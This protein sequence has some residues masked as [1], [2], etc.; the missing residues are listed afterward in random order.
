MSDSVSTSAQ[1]STEIILG[2]NEPENPP[3]PSP[4]KSGTGATGVG[5][6]AGPSSSGPGGGSSEPEFEDV[7]EEL[8]EDI[9]QIIEEPD[10]VDKIPDKETPTKPDEIPEEEP[11]IKFEP[12]NFLL[13]M[14]IAFISLVV[15]IVV[16]RLKRITFFG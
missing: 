13:V 12:P 9:Q 1:P 5:P 6:S 8:T 16:S 14:M 7:P 15:A 10:V 3:P 4:I 2:P 11:I